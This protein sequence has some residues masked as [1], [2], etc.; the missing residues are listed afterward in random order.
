VK[1]LRAAEKNFAADCEAIL[2][3][4]TPQTRLIF[5][6]SPNN[7]T[8]TRVSNTA[9][10]RF[11]RA[12]PEHLI[13]VLDEAYY[14]FLDNPPD[15]ISWI[16][17]GMK[18]VLLRTFSKIHGLAGLRIGYGLAEPALADL[19][20]R[21]R[22]PFNTSSIAQV[23]ALAGLNDLD[24]RKRTKELTDQGRRKL[25]SD[26][27][28]MKLE[29]VPSSANFVL[30]NVGDGDA[31]FRNLLQKGI[32][33]R[34]MVSYRLPGYIRVSIGTPGQMT[35]FLQELPGAMRG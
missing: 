6:A 29:Y 20:Q 7:P 11:V 32:I 27:A 4:I 8:G 25:E 17:E 30:V 2:R 24:H 5:L 21:T 31:V 1:C 28:K 26:F 3:L 18:V 33:V 34:S 23:A 19:L 16:K 35:R 12:L 10:D 15:S 14:E 9:L 22:Q 13:M